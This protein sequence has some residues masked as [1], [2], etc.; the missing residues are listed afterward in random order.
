MASPSTFTNQLCPRKSQTKTQQAC[1]EDQRGSPPS[2]HGWH[3]KSWTGPCD[4]ENLPLNSLDCPTY[5]PHKGVP[6]WHGATAT[7]STPHT[8]QGP[9]FFLFAVREKLR[10]IIKYLRHKMVAHLEAAGFEDRRVDFLG[11]ALGPKRLATDILSINAL[12]QLDSNRVSNYY[13]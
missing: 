2:A 3:P 7:R 13:L 10:N 8:P 1:H 6:A 4:Q 5:L 11:A 12:K 9:L